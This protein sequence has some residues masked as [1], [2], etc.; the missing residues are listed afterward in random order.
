[1]PARSMDQ[2][3]PDLPRC[4]WPGTVEASPRM[5]EQHDNARGVP[6]RDERRHFDYLL[7]DTFQAGAGRS[8]LLNRR[9]KFRR[10]FDLS[11]RSGLRVTPGAR[12]THCAAIPASSACA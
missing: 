8:T 10:A 6:V 11:N 5:L 12:S 1:M 4:Q 9:E 7:L 2:P 3:E